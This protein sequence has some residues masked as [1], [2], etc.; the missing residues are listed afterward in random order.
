MDITNGMVLEKLKLEGELE[1]V[2]LK[3]SNARTG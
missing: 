2:A 3:V 1:I